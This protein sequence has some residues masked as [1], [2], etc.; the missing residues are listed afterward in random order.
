[1]LSETIARQVKNVEKCKE[2]G[3]TR[4]E[5]KKERKKERNKQTKTYDF[6]E[7]IR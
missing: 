7:T 5:A 4:K 1:M 6:R 3:E 2:I